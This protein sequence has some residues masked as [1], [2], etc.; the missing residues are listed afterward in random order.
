[1]AD[2]LRLDHGVFSEIR[3]AEKGISVVG[4]VM[5]YVTNAGKEWSSTS[6]KD[7]EAREGIYKIQSYLIQNVT[8]GSCS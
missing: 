2:V 5:K 1:M 6:A 4:R 7:A 3:A 8:G